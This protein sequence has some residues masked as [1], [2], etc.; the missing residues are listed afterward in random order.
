MQSKNFLKFFTKP[1]PNKVSRQFSVI[2][3]YYTKLTC[4]ASS[5]NTKKQDEG[6]IPTF[7]IQPGMKLAKSPPSLKDKSKLDDALKIQV[8]IL[9]TVKSK[10]CKA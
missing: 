8:I 5:S 7:P 2:A 3:Q 6:W 1:S 10:K 4:Q 9:I